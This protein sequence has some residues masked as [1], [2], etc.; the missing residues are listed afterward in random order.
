M[1]RAARHADRHRDR[2]HRGAT[3]MFQPQD[4]SHP[5]HRHARPSAVLPAGRSTASYTTGWEATACS[6]IVRS[7]PSGATATGCARSAALV[8]SRPRRSARTKTRE[9]NLPRWVH[10]SLPWITWTSLPTHHRAS[11]RGY[12]SSCRQGSSSGCRLTAANHSLWNIGGGPHAS[13]RL[14]RPSRHSRGMAP[15]RRP[16]HPAQCRNG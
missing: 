14:L 9:T 1:H 11:Q 16:R 8:W 6:I 12:S 5:S 15:R 3:R 4:L 2:A 10:R 13:T 7:S